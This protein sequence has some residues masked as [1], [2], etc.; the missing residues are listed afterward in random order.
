MYLYYLAS[1]C[2]E[3]RLFI[4]LN[5]A[6]I[7]YFSVKG[8]FNNNKQLFKAKFSQIHSGLK[9]L[10]SEATTHLRFTYNTDLRRYFF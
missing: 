10:A 8:S 7:A 5:T 4:P 3:A 1:T 6:L 2:I 9:F